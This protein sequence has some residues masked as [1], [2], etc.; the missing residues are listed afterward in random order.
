MNTLKAKLEGV[1]IRLEIKTKELK[2]KDGFMRSVI[3]SRVG[4][5][6]NQSEMEYLT[7]KLEE[8][9]K[10]TQEETLVNTTET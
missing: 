1:Q 9:L 6:P 7:R 8:F 5:E 3:V 2:E 4:K 10:P